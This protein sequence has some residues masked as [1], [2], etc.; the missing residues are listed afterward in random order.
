MKM[1][2]V[3]P[4]TNTEF[5]SSTVPET[6]HAA[7]AAGT[8][9]NIGDRVIVVATHSIYESVTNG[10]SGNDPTTDNGTNWVLISATNRWKAFDS[11]IADQTVFT[12]DMVYNLSPSITVD[13]L[14]FLNVQAGSIRVWVR[15]DALTETYYDQ[16]YSLIDT[17]EVIDWFSFFFSGV[18]YDSEF[19]VSGVPGY[20]GNQ[21]RVEVQVVSGDSYI[22]EIILGKLQSLGE[23]SPGTSIGIR[24]F[25][26]KERDTFGNAFLLERSFIDETVFQF[27]LATEDARR[28]KRILARNRAKPSVYFSDE[29]DLKFGTTIYGYFQDF[30]IPLSVGEISFA[31]LE[32]EGLT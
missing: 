20:V 27:A 16:T 3:L 5:L 9:Y 19:I 2:E 24:D 30:N 28:V 7:Y 10:N 18:D 26:T 1:I 4:I 25:S 12:G 8:T 22:G 23:T 21:I 14:A 13:A 11:K 17:T 29:D 31:T 6:D 15:N 32:V